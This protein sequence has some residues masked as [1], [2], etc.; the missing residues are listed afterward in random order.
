MPKRNSLPMGEAS[1]RSAA[2]FSTVSASAQD[3]ANIDTQSSDRQAGTAPS[4]LIRP[5]VG[6]NPTTLLKPAGTRPEP[7]VSV[8][9]EKLTRPDATA[10]AEPAL[11]PPGTTE[12]P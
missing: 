6:F 10:P 2:T 9:S 8:P 4:T 5:G 3:S 11:E 12:G 1:R 7:A